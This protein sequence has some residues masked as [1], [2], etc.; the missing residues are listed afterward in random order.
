MKNKLKVAIDATPLLGSKTGVGEFTSGLINAL[1]NLDIDTQAFAVSWRNRN[2]LLAHI[3]K[4]MSVMSRPIPARPMH[5]LWERI[6]FPPIE[7]WT[8]KIDV[9]HGTNFV[10]PPSL[11]A[12]R[13]MT[14]HDLTTLKYPQLCNESTKK[15]PA[16][17]KKALLE[18]AW[19]H[20]PSKFVAEEVIDSLG[21]PR[22]RVLAI[23]SG[24]P[25]LRSGEDTSVQKSDKQILNEQLEKA[26]FAHAKDK[27]YILALGTIEPRKDL[28]T[29]IKA[30]DEIAEQ[31]RDLF[32]FIVGQDGWGIQ[33]YNDAFGLMHHKKKVVRLGFVSSKVRYE[34]I[35]H[36][37]VFAYPSLYEGFGFP[38]L[39]AMALGV[40]VVST[41]A[42]A[43]PE[44]LGDAA[45][46]VK[47]KDVD[48]LGQSLSLCLSD[49]SIKKSLIEKGL[50]RAQLFSWEKCAS[51]MASFYNLAS[52]SK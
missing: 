38:P 49:Q 1:V 8:G 5:L 20:T 43:L 2:Q 48:G 45:I 51:E 47:P 22:E 13:I 23:H 3:P 42:G 36:A 4:A 27:P 32:L 12:A 31:Y 9:V 50:Q 35:Q 46:L 17:I 18:G 14:V 41:T 24:I 15:F 33:Q 25:I 28:P 34:L 11:A 52:K 26:G 16:L 29:L 21:A 10:V 37:T 7:L 19:I 44:V 39:E 40:S 6:N 30:F